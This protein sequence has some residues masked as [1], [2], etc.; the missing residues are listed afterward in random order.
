[1][2]TLHCYHCVNLPSDAVTVLM[3]VT[4]ELIY[5]ISYILRYILPCNIRA[6]KLLQ[7]STCIFDMISAFIY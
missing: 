5:V 1:M 4:C 7:P 2:T 6:Y 3:V